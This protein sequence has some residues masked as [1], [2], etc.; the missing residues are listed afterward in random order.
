M[1][2][3]GAVNVAFGISDE[4]WQAG[5]KRLQQQTGKTIK[6]VDAQFKGFDKSVTRSLG[7]VGYQIQDVAVQAQ[8]GTSAMVIFTQQGSQIASAFGPSGA[9]IGALIAVAGIIGTTLFNATEETNLEIDKLIEG[10]LKLT[11]AKKAL[12][13]LRL[14][15]RLDE[16]TQ[17]YQNQL[18][19]LQ[20]LEA[21]QKRLLE[22][23]PRELAGVDKATRTVAKSYD[24]LSGTYTEITK[25]SEDF[26]KALDENNK[27]III[28][29][30]ALEDKSLAIDKTKEAQAALNGAT[31]DAILDN[32]EIKDSVDEVIKSYTIQESLLGRTDRS[33]AKLNA[34]LRVG[35][36]AYLLNKDAIDK[37]ID[38]YYDAI[39]AQEAKI[40]ADK[41]EQESLKT[42]AKEREKYESDRAQLGMDATNL[43][44][45][46]I[47]SQTEDRANQLRL[48]NAWEIEQLR[49]T[50]DIKL[51]NT[52]EYRR[53][54]AAINAK[55]DEQ[56]QEAQVNKAMESYEQ[57]KA[58]YNAIGSLITSAGNQYANLSS[59]LAGA[60]DEEAKQ[61]KK[62]FLLEQA[63]AAASATLGY[64]GALSQI[65]AT[66][67]EII[68][69]YTL[70]GVPGSE[71]AGIAAGNVFKATQT[72]K[73]STAL[74][75]SLSGIA[76]ATLGG[77]AAFYTGADMI[78]NDQLAYLHQGERIVQPN[79]NRDLTNYL[80]N[81]NGSSNGKSDI[82]INQ[83]VNI[84]GTGPSFEQ[85]V[86]RILSKNPKQIAAL[87]SRGE[88]YRPTQRGR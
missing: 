75:T 2:Q 84:N 26:D 30:A 86:L 68:A 45:Q 35:N 38:S 23:R 61:I 5:L 69:A 80:N 53:K 11:S 83:P 19:K 32:E 3:G 28:A 76:A 39:D 49:Q 87:V 37:A 56:I 22:E 48:Q 20:S 54:E 47:I 50:T 29:T 70:P 63:A 62:A 21:E 40:R 27:K 13:E 7:N 74:A 46:L 85:D 24:Y 59:S 58:Y 55:Y 14:A 41:A 67:P 8:L 17:A 9:I 4:Q 43:E 34:Q 51:Q 33:Q 10:T 73:A 81:Q 66:V 82:N 79:V 52:E 64:Y 36:L 6:T 65:D 60:T 57:Q 16:E 1:A 18:T 88:K 71:A 31:N 72:A 78:S 15:E 12:Y 25:S 42:L 77:V 44:R